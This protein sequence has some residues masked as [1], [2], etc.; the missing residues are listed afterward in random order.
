[1]MTCPHCQAELRCQATRT[2]ELSG[3]RWVMRLGE[4]VSLV[5]RRRACPVHGP[6]STVEVPL[7]YLQSLEEVARGT[8]PQAA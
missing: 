7:N 2:A 6:V 4:Q 1:M 5:F 3:V 8:N